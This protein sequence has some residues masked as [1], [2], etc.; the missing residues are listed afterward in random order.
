MSVLR[1]LLAN[2]LVITSLVVKI[3]KFGLGCGDF[4]P[5]G[6]FEIDNKVFDLQAS[7]T[8]NFRQFERK[9]L[10]LSNFFARIYFIIVY[11]YF[12]VFMGYY[13]EGFYERATKIRLVKSLLAAGAV[14]ALT[15]G[16]L[17]LLWKLVLISLLP[18]FSV[19]IGI[20]AGAIVGGCCYILLR[21]TDKALA[22]RLDREFGLSERVKTMLEY[23]GSDERI[24]VLQRRDTEVRLENIPTSSLAA[25]RIW[26][27]IAAAVLGLAMLVVGAVIPDGRIDGGGG[28]VVPYALSPLEEAG[29]N[30][31]ISYVTSSEAKEP[32]RSGIIT[33]LEELLAALKAAE[34]EAEMHAALAVC[35]T[36]ITEIT[37]DSSSMTEILDAMWATEGERVR[38]LVT[39]LDTSALSEPDWGAFADGYNEFKKIMTEMPEAQTRSGGAAEPTDAEKKAYV[40]WALEDLTIKTDGALTSSGIKAGDPLYDVLKKLI[41]VGNAGASAQGFG[42]ILASVDGM[43]YAEASAAVSAAIDAMAEGIYGACAEIKINASTGEYVLRRLAV[44]FSVKIPQFERPTLK[45]DSASSGGD[46]EDSSGGGGVGEGIQ[47]GSDDLVLDP[48]TGD[49]VKYGELYSRYNTLMLDK[50]SNGKY[51]YTDEQ[52]RAIEKYFA[53]LYSGLK[54]DE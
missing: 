20:G 15:A 13:F 12:G 36:E 38:A 8:A 45:E 31:L 30:E 28:E 11:Y 4:L 54:D 27:Y 16:V 17:I 43:G 52:K 37:Y 18:I 10:T 42:A 32:Y 26:I 2:A 9:A 40:K 51:D 50:L 21:F 33:E 1:I 23:K 25:R 35:L 6:F 53:L 48:I 19:L 44:L 46:E 34:T 47:F 49:Y 24:H 3:E 5:F 7:R 39:A 14:G 29:L 22:G 41:G